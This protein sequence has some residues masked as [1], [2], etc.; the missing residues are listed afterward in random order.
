MSWF[1]GYAL[2]EYPVHRWLKH[3]EI[4]CLL[5]ENCSEQ[6]GDYLQV[7]SLVRVGINALFKQILHTPG[8]T[9]DSLCVYHNNSNTLYVG[10]TIY[11]DDCVLCITIQS[12]FTR[13]HESI[14]RLIHFVHKCPEGVLLACG[15]RNDRMPAVQVDL[16]I[17]Y[18]LIDARS[19]AA[20][21]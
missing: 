11:T 16:Q 7:C 10:D 13:L 15:H 5:H 14:Q 9:P 8:H 12:D 3:D 21:L 19:A 1:Y 20:Q 6:C 17:A 4:I 18:S 2:E